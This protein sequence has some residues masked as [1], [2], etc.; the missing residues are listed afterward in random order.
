MDGGTPSPAPFIHDVVP[1][2]HT[3]V[4]SAEGFV[5]KTETFRVAEGDF[6]ARELQLKELA[7]KLYIRTEGGAQVLVDGRI[8]GSAPFPSYVEVEPGTRQV[9]VTHNGFEPVVR[10]VEIARGETKKI[11][12]GLAATGQRRISRI[13]LGLGGAG[14]LTG[15]IFMGIAFAAESTAKGLRDK[16]E[17]QGL[18]QGELASYEGARNDRNTWLGAS[19]VAFGMSGAIGATGMLLYLFDQP[20]LN[21]TAPK[22]EKKPDTP[23]GPLDVTLG[24]GSVTISGTF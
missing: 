20:P 8:V 21:L 24:L 23:K 22:T 17:L 4:V 6:V 3:F 5:T 7:G 10:E 14:V 11:D 18:M 1:G 9:A 13:L 16:R 19:L 12:I 15:G 2:D